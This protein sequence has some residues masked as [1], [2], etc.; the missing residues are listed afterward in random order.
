MSE[1]LKV[2]SRDQLFS[3][4]NL[5]YRKMASMWNIEENS[6]RW[7]LL[8]CGERCRLTSSIEAKIKQTVV[9][10]VSS[11]MTG[12]ARHISVPRGA[13]IVKQVRYDPLGM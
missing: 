4:L 13:P 12:F 9:K 10:L 7:I 8:N 5:G 11:A 1:K 3:W 6:P 2:V